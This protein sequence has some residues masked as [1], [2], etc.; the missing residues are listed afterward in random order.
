MVYYLVM[1]TIFELAMLSPLFILLGYGLFGLIMG[2][3]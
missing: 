3:E 1:D 2:W